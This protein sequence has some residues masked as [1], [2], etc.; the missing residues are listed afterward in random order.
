[1]TGAFLFVIGASVVLLLWA[2]RGG[3][4]FRTHR[5]VRTSSLTWPF[6][7]ATGS[8]HWFHAAGITMRRQRLLF[9]LTN[10]H[11]QESGPTRSWH[12]GVA[13]TWNLH[14]KEPDGPPRGA[15]ME[16][17]EIVGLTFALGGRDRGRIRRRPGHHA[18][19][20]RFDQARVFELEAQAQSKANDLVEQAR[21]DAEHLAKDAEFRT[22]DELFRKRDEFNRE[23]ET[24]APNC[25]SRNAASK[26]AKTPPNRS[27]SSRSRRS[28]CSNITEETLRPQGQSRKALEGTRRPDQGTDRTAARDHRPVAASRRRRCCSNGS[29]ANWPTRS[30]CASRSTKRRYRAEGEEKAREILATAIQRYAAEHTADTTVSTVDIPSDDMKGRIIGREGRNIRTF[31]KATGVDVIVDDTPGVVIVSAFDNVRRETARLALT[32]LIQDGRIHPSRIEEVVKETQ[33]EMEKH[34]LEVGKQAVQEANVGHAA[35]EARSSCW[36]G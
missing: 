14:F 19:A 11:E 25:A 18:L 36:A 34:I 30:P 13:R 6:G 33:E 16:T 32:K 9:P 10:G 24:C 15:P 5:G 31:E 1:M 22:K 3:R 8:C 2:A 7:A 35:R 26:S 28:A 12:F 17:P 20:L 21:R 23:M 27:T 4:A 29:S